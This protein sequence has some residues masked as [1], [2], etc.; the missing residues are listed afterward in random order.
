MS[1]QMAPLPLAK[2]TMRRTRPDDQVGHHPRKPPHEH[3][4]ACGKLREE[5]V[6]DTVRSLWSED[7]QE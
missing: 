7:R 6:R 2:T 5:C 1:T 4:C 3:L